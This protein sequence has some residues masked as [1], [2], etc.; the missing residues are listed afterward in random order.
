VVSIRCDEYGFDCNYVTFG[1]IEGVVFDYWKHMNDSH[2]IDYSKGT[3]GKFATKKIRNTS[4]IKS[5]IDT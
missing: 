5:I 2:G 4:S 1:E 3:V